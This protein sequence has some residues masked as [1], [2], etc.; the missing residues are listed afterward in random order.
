MEKIKR[1]I[2]M[3]WLEHSDP[4]IFYTLLIGGVIII[5]QVLNQIAI[6]KNKEE[7]NNTNI[8][9]NEKIIYKSN[10]ED[11]EL[12]NKFIKYCKEKNLEGAYSLL[13]EECKNELYPTLEEFT[14]KY[15]SRVFDKKC[16]T[17]IKYDENNDLYNI[18][19][20]EDMLET[21]KIENKE[22]AKDQYKIIQ[23][24]LDKKIY[25]NYNQEIK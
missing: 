5:V 25:I 3:F 24:I 10:P 1:K 6:N 15:Y 7:N 20:F 17:S 16:N 12:I 8:I 14:N 18:T 22:I 2:K 4:I 9:Q 13:S 21:G 23:E 19:F 11:V